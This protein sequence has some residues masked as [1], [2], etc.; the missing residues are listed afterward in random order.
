VS[1]PQQQSYAAG[2]APGEDAGAWGRDTPSYTGAEYGGYGGEQYQD[3]RQYTAGGA[4]DQTYQ[5]DP[6]QG[7]QYD[8]YAYGGQPDPGG[9]DPSYDA[10]YDQTYQQGYDASYDPAQ[11]HQHGSERSDG[12]QQ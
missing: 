3:G 10:S 12:S 2:A 7:G 4:Y 11:P 6:Y 5:A 8:P 1:I 9:Y